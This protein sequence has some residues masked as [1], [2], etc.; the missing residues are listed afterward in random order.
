M[1]LGPPDERAGSLASA[2]ADG[3][4]AKTRAPPGALAYGRRLATA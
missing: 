1:E 3:R 2:L 4:R